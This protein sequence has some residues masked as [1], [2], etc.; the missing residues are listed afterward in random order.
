MVDKSRFVGLPRWPRGAICIVWLISCLWILV[1]TALAVE[2]RSPLPESLSEI[3]RQGQRAHNR[4]DFE[5]AVL[6]WRTAERQL[7]GQRRPAAHAHVSIQLGLGLAGLGQYERALPYLH[8]ALEAARQAALHQHVPVALLSLGQVYLSMDARERAEAYLQQALD[9]MGERHDGRVRAA[10]MHNL[11]NVYVS[12]RQVQ[13]KK[14]LDYY[15]QS[16]KLAQQVGS[17]AMAARSL[18]HAATILLQVYTWQDFAPDRPMTHRPT[19]AIGR[20][21]APSDDLSLNELMAAY[22]PSAIKSMLDQAYTNL[23]ALPPSHD[24]AYDLTQVGLAYDHMRTALSAP[25]PGLLQ[26]AFNAFRLALSMADRLR[27]QRAAAYA[28]GH[29]GHLYETSQRYREA[30]QLT[31]RAVSAAQQ[32][33]H[34]A[35]LYPWQW[36]TGRLLQA[37]GQPQAAIEAYQRAIASVEILREGLPCAHRPQRDALQAS[38]RALFLEFADLLLQR[39]ARL[40]G[41]DE[42]AVL[43]RAQGV[44]EQYKTA[45]LQAYLGDYCLASRQ[46]EPVELQKVTND[47]IIIYPIPLAARLELLVSF[48]GKLQRFRVEVT[49]TQ[50]ADTANGFRRAIE[51]GQ[52]FYLQ[53]AQDLY[54]WLVRPF[55]HLIPPG[56]TLVF[57]PQGPLLTI[58]LAALHDGQRFVIE[59]YPVA[60]T[61]GL[62]LI[63]PEPLAKDNLRILAAGVTTSPG[64]ELA[65]LPHV[66]SELDAIEAL[67]PGRVYRLS[68][69]RVGELESVWQ[70]RDFN[71]VHIASHGVFSRDVEASF[72]L[73]ANGERLTMQRLEQIVKRARFRE[74]PLALMA[75]SACETA[76]GDEQAALGLAGI[77]V[78]AGARSVLATLWQV[79]DQAAATLV[80]SFY[81]YIQLPNISRAHALQRAQRDL[82]THVNADWRHPYYWSAFLMIN[83]WL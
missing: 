11:G 1:A 65:T 31:R 60:V 15:Q 68:E 26:A 75:L 82:I 53:L 64:P 46:T 34:P 25:P 23:Q 74:D 49:A 20:W 4:G 10:I 58:P 59:T 67:F 32:V 16:V 69:F 8:R 61:P 52:P 48:S 42:V 39:A 24:Q 62:F 21:R 29:L 19:L 35:S 2:E 27:N 47:A 71:M 22:P 9:T 17:D 13:P 70:R 5:Q 81:K 50:L 76:I 51:E 37:L 72:L 66:K 78:K 43:N 41:E 7:A 80:Q 40:Q 56:R 57:V 12:G 45:E 55:E 18:T 36:Q 83:S 33:N 77:A 73:A 44:V 38:M 30:L 3:I 14:A 6:A 54:T 79:E 28:A 63:E